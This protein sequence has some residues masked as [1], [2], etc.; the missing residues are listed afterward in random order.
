[1]PFKFRYG[2]KFVETLTLLNDA[3]QWSYDKSKSFQLQALKDVLKYSANIPYYKRL[4]RDNGFDYNIKDFDQLK[5]LPPLTKE[6]I[7]K[8][9]NSLSHPNYPHK[10]YDMHTSGTTGTRLHILGTDD[11]FKVE[12]AFITNAH[13][14]HGSNLYADHSI[15]IRRYSPQ[16]GDPI[17]RDDIELNRSYMSAFDLNDDTIFDYIRYI[18]NKKSKILVSYPSTIYYLAVLCEKHNLELKHVKYLHGASEMCL[19]QWSDKI[20]SVFGT[21]LKMHYGQVEK[22]SFAHQDSENNLYKENLLYSYN[23]LADDNTFI[24]TGFHNYLMPLIRYKTN[25]VIMKNPNAVLDSAFPKTILKI[26]GRNGDM[27][28]TEKDS[29]VPAVNFYS[30]MSKLNFVDMFQIT[31]Q[32]NNKSVKF[33]IVPNKKFNKNNEKLL[34]TEMHNR[35]GDVPISILKKKHIRRDKNTSKFKAVRVI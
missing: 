9:F 27:L 16:T 17:F 22:A 32:K 7:I 21:E 34:Y 23:E 8:N 3:K 26:N 1:M 18:N 25:D 11:L 6:L 10:K 4:F 35:L 30:F 31:Q 14:D 33:Y 13:N 20:K 24:G 19:D 12:C 5:N 29:L 15:W 2:T 28:I